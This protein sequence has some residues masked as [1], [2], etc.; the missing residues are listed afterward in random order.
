LD[1]S[2]IAR[3]LDFI[4]DGPGDVP[5]VRLYQFNLKDIQ[6]LLGSLFALASGACEKSEVH[7]LAKAENVDGAKLLLRVGT[8]DKG[9]VRLPGVAS[10][11][12]V[13]TAK[14]WS[15]LA[16]LVEPFQNEIKGF[17]W[18][19]EIGEAKLLLSADGRW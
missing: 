17:R 8:K 3:K 14:S 16:Y 5:L 19:V 10:F 11:E 4:A 18:L 12:C 1:R 15:T 7:A 2:W 13:L 6:I 9:M